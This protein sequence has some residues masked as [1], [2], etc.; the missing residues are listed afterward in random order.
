MVVTRREERIVHHFI[1]LELYRAH[2]AEWERRAAHRTIREPKAHPR[3]SL[4]LFSFRKHRRARFTARAASG[5]H[6]CR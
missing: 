1:A 5:A 2:L 6:A 4:S 3:R